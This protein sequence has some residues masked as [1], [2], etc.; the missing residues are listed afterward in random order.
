[1]M[2]N[3]YDVVDEEFNFNIMNVIDELINICLL[4]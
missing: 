1:M 2:F 4:F 3:I